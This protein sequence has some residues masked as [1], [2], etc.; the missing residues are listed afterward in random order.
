MNDDPPL[1]RAHL[2]ALRFLSYRP[3][4][5]TEVKSRLRSRFPAPIVEQVLELLKDEALVDDVRFASEWRAGR[6][7]HN[8]RSGWAIK[9]ELVAKGVDGLVAEEAV[10]DVDDEDNAY[11]AGLKAAGRLEGSDMLT[12]NRRLWSHLKR[13]GFS[14]SVSRRTIT[15]L[16]EEMDARSESGMQEEL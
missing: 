10:R 4:T 2:V 6:E 16:W 15:Q 7:S 9:R 3:R 11:R 14:D 8:P 5:E 13:R 12:F 1:R